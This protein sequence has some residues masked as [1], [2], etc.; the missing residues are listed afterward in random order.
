MDR[1]PQALVALL[2][3]VVL[4]GAAIAVSGSR[5]G[6]DAQGDL[7]WLLQAAAYLCAAVGGA[8]LLMG[9][10]PA[11]KRNGGIVLGVTVVLALVDA[12]TAGSDGADIGAGL[13]RLVGLVVLAYV[14]TRLSLAVSAS[15]RSA[16]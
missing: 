2:L 12:L 7:P 9:Q 6:G 5:P 8:L 4:T 14:I 15:R 13:A 3:F 10:D 1:R 11:A 16:S